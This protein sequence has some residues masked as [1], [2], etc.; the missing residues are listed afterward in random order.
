MSARLI[1][2]V[3]IL[4]LV[5]S[6]NLTAQTSTGTIL[7]TVVDPTDAALSGVEVTVT[8]LNTGISRP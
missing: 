1:T 3:L 5:L 8:E 6:P 7:G 4:T 2:L